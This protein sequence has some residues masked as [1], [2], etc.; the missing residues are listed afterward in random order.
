VH[1]VL[2]ATLAEWK[3]GGWAEMM[4]RAPTSDA[5]VCDGSAYLLG[6]WDPGAEFVPQSCV[7]QELR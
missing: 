3:L 7:E 5:E 1:P 4:G 2:A 6:L